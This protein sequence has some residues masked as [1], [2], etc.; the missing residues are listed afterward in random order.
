MQQ[1]NISKLK[2]LECTDN[3]LDICVKNLILE[4][5]FWGE[6]FLG[7]ILRQRGVHVQR[8]RLRKSLH[9]VDDTGVSERKRIC[10]KRRM[11]NVQGQ[12]Y[13]WYI[14]T[15]HK[16]IRWNLIIAGGIDGFNRLI[17]FL[18]CLDNNRADSLLHVFLEGVDSFGIPQRVRSDKGLENVAIAD[19]MIKKRGI[20]RGSM[21]TAKSVH[22]QRIE[23]LWRNIYP[24]VLCFYYHLFYH[25]KDEGILDPLNDNQIAAL[26]FT[27]I[28]Y[29][30]NKLSVWREAW[31]HDNIRTVKSSPINLGMS[32][33]LQNSVRLYDNDL[34]M[35]GIKGSLESSKNLVPEDTRPAILSVLSNVVSDRC[36]AELN[37]QIQ[38]T[39]ICIGL[40][41]TEELKCI[42]KY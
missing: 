31:A 28:P 23:R 20:G 17:T 29:I 13:F 37:K 34:E 16:L 1:Y 5:P 39:S 10:L 22:N 15:N 35:H 38:D 9:R 30:N 21:T 36:L 19:F 7:Q 42:I 24:G 11:Y 3:E 40:M 26:Q 2:F 6:S 12:N 4:F 18:K 14:D 27:F 8:Y 32:G 33:K 25:M 41:L